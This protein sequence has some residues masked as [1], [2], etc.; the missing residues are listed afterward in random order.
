MLVANSFVSTSLD[1]GG[2][3]IDQLRCST[4][5]SIRRAIAIGF[6]AFA[7]VLLAGPIGLDTWSEFGFSDV[8]VAAT[9]C[10]PADPA[11]AFCVESSGTP[12]IFLDAPPW[13]FTTAGPSLLTVTD[14]FTSGDRFE[15]FDFGVSLGLTSLPG[16]L[17]VDCGDDPVV[18]L[19]TAGVSRA[20]F[21][22]AAGGHALTLFPTLSP[23]GGGSGY[24]FVAAAVPE[25]SSLALLALGI[26]IVGVFLIV[27]RRKR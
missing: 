2:T 6:V 27:G 26:V 5:A 15:V 7:P 14:A 22:L 17:E 25:P 13:T 4:L 23:G 19:A 12:T 3:M 8:G 18:C 11:G 21:S 10:D 20:F 16:A 24:L 1:C 9:G